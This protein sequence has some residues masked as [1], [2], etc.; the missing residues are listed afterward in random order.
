MLGLATFTFLIVI[1]FVRVILSIFLKILIW[2]FG[3]RF[4]IKEI[5]KKVSDNI[6]FNTILAMS[7]EGLIEFIIYGYLNFKT[8]DFT[9]NGEVLGFGFGV[10]SLSMSG[11]ILPVILIVL[12]SIKSRR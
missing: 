9:L 1:Y 7:I 11:F 3:G 8:A 6:F 2:I 4:N 10:F 5:F 12:L